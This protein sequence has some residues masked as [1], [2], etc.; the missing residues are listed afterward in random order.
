MRCHLAPSFF[1]LRPEDKIYV[2][3]SIYQLVEFCGI[4]YTEAW[5]MPVTVR[6]WW[7]DEKS[8]EIEEKNRKGGAPPQEKR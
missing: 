4:T 8:K 3:K 2:Y 1:G 6:R 7:I 5:D